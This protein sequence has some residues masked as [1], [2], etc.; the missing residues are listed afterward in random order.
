MI[1]HVLINI[2]LVISLIYLFYRFLY[3]FKKSV[4]EHPVTRVALLT[5]LAVVLTI[6]TVEIDGYIISMYFVPLLLI[7][8]VR[9]PFLFFISYGLVILTAWLT[10]VLY[11]EIII[12]FLVAYTLSRGLN[13]KLNFSK[14][15][16]MTLSH[17]LFIFI[18]FG[19]IYFVFSEISLM[20]IAA[21]I[22]V[23]HLTMFV[24]T[25]ILNDINIIARILNR[26]EQDEYTDHLTQLGNVKALDRDV[27]RWMH[28]KNHI[29]MYLIDI[30]GFSAYNE[31]YGYRTGDS[32][33]RQMVEALKNTSPQGAL[34]FRN[35][36]E[37]FTMLIPELS[38]DKSV[39]LADGIR[40][41]IEKHQFHI[42]EKE[43]ISLTITIGIGYHSKSLNTNK[44]TLFKDA[45]D[46]LHAAK[47]Q[48]QN[49][50][51]FSPLS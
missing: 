4:L 51:M 15:I 35:G 3:R 13:Y 6:F 31:H 36:G 24:T 10:D 11:V 50:I 45:N 20:T 22:I 49:Q 27:E 41:N 1:I 26:Y 8:L 23:A 37:E 30:D 44:S 32:I 2:T 9:Q 16:N 5:M 34:L 40:K 17:S 29:T 48:G 19:I 47:K 42:N 25:V 43:Q 46:M 7:S 14:F 28:S 21:A 39:R 38:L 18:Y 33:I 12:I